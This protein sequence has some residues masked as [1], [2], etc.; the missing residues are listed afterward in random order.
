MVTEPLNKFSHIIITQLL[1][2]FRGYHGLLKIEMFSINIQT[3]Q[4][5]YHRR[6]CKN[7]F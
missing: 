1:A 3:L 6:G 7:S 4:I 2:V 5:L